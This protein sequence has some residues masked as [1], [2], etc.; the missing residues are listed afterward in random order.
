VREAE[1][2]HSTL[3]FDYRI[4]AHPFDAKSD[5]LP[6]APTIKRSP[7]HLRPSR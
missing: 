2:G 5:R 4:V 6:I 7:E 3:S 1:N